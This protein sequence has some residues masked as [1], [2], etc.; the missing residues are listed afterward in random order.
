MRFLGHQEWLRFGFRDLIIRY[1]VNLDIISS[2]EYETNFF[3]FRYKGNLNSFLDW[4]VYFYGAY[5]KEVLFFLRDLVSKRVDPIF[6][7][8]GANVG[9]HSLFMSKYCQ[10]VHAFEPYEKVR[11]R[12]LEKITLNNIDNITVHGVGLGDRDE[13]LDYYAPI[14]ANLATGSFLPGHGR[15][16]NRLLG[17]LKLVKGDDFLSS[18]NLDRVDLIKIDVEGF[19][20]FV[21]IGLKETIATYRLWIFLEFSESTQETL[22]NSRG[23]SEILP[24]GYDI[25]EFNVYNILDYSLIFSSVSTNLKKFDFSKHHV[26]L[27]LKHGDQLYFC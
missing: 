15:N 10:Q 19:E 11:N 22:S 21:L 7:D 9:Q 1:F 14:G 26:N 27:V 23:L 18:L 13:Y 12:L 25:L 16:N 6:L 5:E 3:G 2:W 4:Y 17:K 20:Q 24:A 8:V